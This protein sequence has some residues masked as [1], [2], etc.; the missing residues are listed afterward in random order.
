MGGGVREFPN[1]EKVIIFDTEDYA[2]NFER[3]MIAYITG[4]IGECGVGVEAADRASKELP[5]DVLTWFEEHVVHTADEH[6]CRRP[7]S[8]VPTPGMYLGEDH[9]HHQGDPEAEGR[10]PAYCSVEL[11]VDEWPGP[12]IMGR[13]AYRVKH[14]CEHFPEFD[15]FAQS[16]LTFTMMRFVERKI[17]QTE[18]E[19]EI[20]MRK[21]LN[22]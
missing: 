8:I 12:E 17:V 3:P 20:C 1:D 16:P 11:V 18:A 21:D 2:G 14:F 4:Q 7:T 5:D 6:G 19:V 10:P 13:I 15:E 22:V 9:E